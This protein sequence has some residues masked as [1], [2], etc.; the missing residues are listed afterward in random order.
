[1]DDMQAIVFSLT[2]Q[3]PRSISRSV[4]D[5]DHFKVREGLLEYA[6]DR[7]TKVVRSVVRRNYD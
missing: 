2:E 4:V 5:N 1:M 7:L 6:F 3:G